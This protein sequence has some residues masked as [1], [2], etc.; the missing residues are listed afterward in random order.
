LTVATAISEVK[1]ALS[2]TDV[3]EEQIKDQEKQLVRGVIP[4]F[5]VSYDDQAVPLNSRQKFKLAWKM[6]VEPVTF[7]VVAVVAGVQ[8]AQNDFSGYGQGAQ[9]YAKRQ[10]R[11]LQGRQWTLGGKL[12]ERPRKPR[13]PRYLQSLL[14]SLYYP[15]ENRHGAG[16]TFENGLIGIGATAAANLLQEFVARKFTPSV[17]KQSPAQP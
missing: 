17:P 13:R 5:Y 9:G 15:A 12:L 3:A 11:D 6:T 7:G 16:L 8:Q 14:P 1:V 4:N 2:Q 10:C